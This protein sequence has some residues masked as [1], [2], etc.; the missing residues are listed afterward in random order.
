M[1]VSYVRLAFASRDHERVS[2]QW[3]T[4]LRDLHA[5]GVRFNVNEGH[6]TMERQAQLVREKGLWSSRNPT[7]AAAPSASAPHIRTGR[8]D[9]AIDFDNAAAVVSA[10]ARRGV[11]LRRPIPTEPWHVEPDAGDLARYYKRRHREALA[12]KAKAAKAKAKAAKA[13]VA[14]AASQ[15][16]AALIAKRHGIGYALLAVREAD[17]LRHVSRS[18]ALAMLEQESRGR[19]VFGHD[20]VANPAPKGGKVTKSRYLRYKAARARQG[21]QGV[22]P[23]QL[24]WW[25]FQDAA[26]RRGG[27]WKPSANI[28]EGLSRLDALISHY[29]YAG[30]IRRYNGTGPAADAYSRSVRT[31]AQAWAKRLG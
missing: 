16:R 25:E 19:N 14:K 8:P 21:M 18:L 7:G 27:C 22:G 23:L 2:R 1:G 10:A 24:T 31:K 29:G 15:A 12:R 11:T 3:Y 28:A 6:R 5:A 30:G 13:K 9:H 26:D 20:P 17:K 4:L